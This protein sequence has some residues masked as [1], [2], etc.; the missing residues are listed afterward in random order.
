[1]KKL[2]VLLLCALLLPILPA[3]AEGMED[4][5][6]FRLV[7]VDESGQEITI[8]SGVLITSEH[9][10]LT[11][12]AMC[13]LGVTAAYA[14]DGTVYAVTNATIYK[15]GFA[16]LELDQDAKMPA[17]QYAEAA[18]AQYWLMGVTRNGLRYSAPA[19]NVTTT[20]YSGQDAWLVSASEALLP[21]AVLVHPDGDLVGLVAA[22]W[23]EGEARYVVLPGSDAVLWA[24]AAIPVGDVR[25]ARNSEWLQDVALT[26]EAGVLMIDWSGSAIRDMSENGGFAV[27]V[28]DTEN[29]Y[30]SYYLLDGN[31]FSIQLLLVPGRE[32]LIG[33]TQ[34]HNGGDN[35]TH[36][37]RKE[38]DVFVVPE[39][40]PLEEYGFTSEC[41]LSAFPIDETPDPVGTLPPMEEITAETLADIST[42]LYIMVINT[43]DVEEEIEASMIFSL[44]TPEGYALF[45]ASGYIFAPEYEERDAWNADVTELFAEYLAYTNGEFAPGEYE[46]RYAIDGV[47]ADTFTFTLE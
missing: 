46:L 20:R 40:G 9:E 4:V 3:V 43:Y 17:A 15:T 44:H 19:T 10:L 31:S 45:S 38:M 25:A 39:A 29:K 2:I 27:Y 13:D 1:M 26:Y 35:I 37:S 34:T 16:Q 36:L 7:T 6:L 28:T 42:S 30:Y 32:Y 22:T 11:S 12:A 24:T 23:G 8:G 41:Y 14:P 33:V 21:G 18:S 5:P 47:W